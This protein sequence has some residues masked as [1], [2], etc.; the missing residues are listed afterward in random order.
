MSARWPWVFRTLPF[1]SWSRYLVSRSKSVDYFSYSFKIYVNNLPF[2][3]LCSHTC[4]CSINFF[5]FLVPVFFA[6]SLVSSVSPFLQPSFVQTYVQWCSL[7]HKSKPSCHPT[8]A[9]V[10]TLYILLLYL[11]SPSDSFICVLYLFSAFIAGNFTYLYSHHQAHETQNA[12]W[13][14]SFFLLYSFI[15]IWLH[16]WYVVLDISTFF[17]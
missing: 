16:P 9:Q 11:P 3:H 5:S 17:I 10:T 4:F 15:L 12:Y 13:R 8:F 6:I 2:Q 7:K 14:N 1:I